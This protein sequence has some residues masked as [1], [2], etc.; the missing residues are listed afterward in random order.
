MNS[1]ARKIS[2]N[3]LKIV[4]TSVVCYFVYKNFKSNYDSLSEFDLSIDWITFSL[5]LLM[6]I[7]AFSLSALAWKAIISGLGYDIGLLKSFKV[8]FL[9]NLGK[10]IP[11][12][13]WQAFGMIY[14]AQKSNIP[15]AV[16]ATSFVLTQLFIIPLALLITSIYLIFNDDVLGELSPWSGIGLLL[17]SGAII[18]VL[19]VRPHS[20]QK[21]INIILKTFKQPE[22]QFAFEARR[23][24]VIDA[25][26]SLVWLSLGLGFCLFVRALL[27]IPTQLTIPL[28]MIY[29][30][31][32]IVGYLSILTPG[33]LGVR[34]GILIVLLSPVLQPGEAALIAVASRFWFLLGEMLCS[35]IAVIIR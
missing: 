18:L 7:L 28:I 25:I 6:I 30:I 8:M 24:I 10:Y 13:I 2:V 5:S 23:A 20:L 15:K 3:I 29:V 16:S 21:P 32:Y 22:M 26:Y 12:K 14:L 17:I 11:G 34:E 31:G 1:S 27:E 4:A 19:I 33:G 9:S 35:L